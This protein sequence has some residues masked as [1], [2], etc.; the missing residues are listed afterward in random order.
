M[1]S[2]TK[3]PTM[4]RRA[5]EAQ[6]FRA[7]VFGERAD[8]MIARSISVIKL[9]LGEPDF[10]A[11]PAV[12]DAMR[13]Q[14]DGRA[15][16]YTAALGLP[17]LRRAIADFYHERHH[18][19]IDPRRI[20]ITAGGSAAL[21]LATALTVDPG[22]EVIVADPSYPCN[23][24]LIRSFEGVVVDVPTSAATRFHLN[25]ELVDR[26]WSERTK[27]VMV[28][29]PS[30]PTGTTIDFDV[31]KGVCDLARFR[32]AWR[33]IDETY[34]DLADREPDGSEVRSAL[35]ADPD[36]IIC[37]SFS[38]FFGMTGW[39]LGWAVVPEYTIEAVD[40]LATNYYLCAHTPTQHA[41][42]ACFTPESLAV[43]E[44]RRQELLARRRIVVSGL[45]RIGLPL[46]V[47]PNGA[48]YAYFSVA[49]TGLDAWTFCERALE[50]A[51]VALTPG[52]DF[53][54]ATADTHVRLSYAASREALTEGLSR[55]GK[56]V[57]SLRWFSDNRGRPWVE[58][59]AH[60]A[61]APVIQ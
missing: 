49:G 58:H 1:M 2:E 3:Q 33:I 36:A 43:C 15:L 59:R 9:S 44:E 51:H 13:E 27:A 4:S 18:V 7:M 45:E 57:A 8:E 10:G 11:P 12:R 30:N 17:E 48:F 34:L 19:D 55:L 56:F 32:G 38:K 40:D 39:R 5:R 61:A 20:V 26:A 54:P 28:T 6:P 42:L 14:Y 52:R 46:E 37:N 35:L 60:A 50:E 47:V 24:E 41:A 25:A 53:G 23:R 31:L 16:P 22:D 29:S 21:L